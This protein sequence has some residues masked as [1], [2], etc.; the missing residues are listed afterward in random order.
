LRG[1]KKDAVADVALVRDHRAPVGQVNH[2]AEQSLQGRR[3]HGARHIVT[4][5]ATVLA[6]E[7]KPLLCERFADTL[8]RE[9]PGIAGVAH[10]GHGPDHV[11]ML[12]PAELRAFERIAAGAVGLEPERLELARHGIMFQAECRDVEAVD[13]VL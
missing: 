7:R 6:E 12:H 11:R 10:D 13:H 9:P 1:G 8:I 2:T 4:A 5:A 3:V